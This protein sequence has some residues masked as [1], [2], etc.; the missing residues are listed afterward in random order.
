MVA[1]G[2]QRAVGQ[3]RGRRVAVERGERTALGE[4]GEA[5][6]EV[7]VDG[8]HP[9]AHERD[10]LRVG[11]AARE[12]VE[13][14]GVLGELLVRGH[15][16]AGVAAQA[17][18]DE[19][20]PAVGV[21][22]DE[23]RA[24]RGLRAQRRL[25]E[26][27]GVVQR[28]VGPQRAEGGEVGDRRRRAVDHRR[29]VARQHAHHA[30]GR[31]VP[32]A[33]LRQAR[34]RLERP[35]RARDRP[36]RTVGAG[37]RAQRA[38]DPGRRGGG[39][40]A[41]ARAVVVGPLHD[42]ADAHEV[43]QR[44]AAGRAGALLADQRVGRPLQ[45]DGAQVGE[46][47]DEARRHGPVGQRREDRVVGPAP[48]VE[49]EELAGQDHRALAGRQRAVEVVGGVAPRRGHAVGQAELAVQRRPRAPA[50]STRPPPARAPRR[51][52]P[53]RRRRG[54]SACTASAPRP[55]RPSDT[56]GPAL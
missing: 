15:G 31:H 32:A 29:A 1:I 38:Q 39:H 42:G 34:G 33:D 54:R 22:D 19:D 18:G 28:A 47:H 11:P 53:R 37:G 56:S 12:R 27:G 30:A 40:R 46:G 41:A 3:P 51:R 48:V 2:G 10:G 13:L 45:V 36:R 14:R 25:V 26:V 9:A 6:R 7:G 23:R 55:A 35:G 44:R 24:A 49:G 20:A 5:G 4:L 21:A 50:A 52:A 16:P 8:G 43:E 17:R